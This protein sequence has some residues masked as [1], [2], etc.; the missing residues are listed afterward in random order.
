MMREISHPSIDRVNADKSG[1]VQCFK[2]SPNQSNIATWGGTHATTNGFVVVWS[3]GIDT[4]VSTVV[5]A[6]TDAAWTAAELT[7]TDIVVLT[8]VLTA[9]NAANL[10]IID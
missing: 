6:G 7:V 3:D 9:F 2:G 5:D 1:T 10:V 4:H 8:G